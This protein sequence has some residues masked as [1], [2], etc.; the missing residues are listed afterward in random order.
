VT[1]RTLT[2]LCAAIFP[3]LGAVARADEPPRRDWLQWRGPARTGKIVAPAWPA[4]LQSE[5]LKPLWR[6]DNLGPSYSGP[7]VAGNRIFTTETRDKKTEVVRAFDR[8]TG[9][10]LWKVEWPGSIDVPFFARSNGSWIRATPA[11]DD[12]RL[13]VAGIRDVLVCLDAA[14]GQELW[15]FD[16]VE[17]FQSPLP[18]FGFVCSP[19]VDGDSVYVQAGAS[20]VRLR[21]QTGEL[22]WRSFEDDGG[23]MGSVFSSP[24]MAEVAGKRQLIVQARIEIAGID[25]ETGRVLWSRPIP[26]ERGMN[27]FTPVVFGDSFFCSAYGGGSRRCDVSRR[28]DGFDVTQK[29]D[30]KYQGYM[31]TPVVLDGHAYMLLRN[32]RLLCLDLETGKEKWITSQIF[33][34]YWSL[35]AN[36]DRILALDEKGILYLIRATPEKFDL[37]HSRK[38]ASA[39]TWA[40]LAIC[41]DELVIRELNA[42]AVFRWK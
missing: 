21:K 11:Y 22:V 7:I 26:A 41:G 29:W 15:R 23:M 4:S 16:F 1:I 37:I 31:S 38:I 28:N 24:I 18:K 33:G 40:H 12:G 3:T 42:L 39:E 2:A 32:Q 34:K 5:A 13:Y 17:K 6:V 25:P 20:C 19:L 27:I 14:T 10:E 8:T 35:V 9:A 36:G 30:S